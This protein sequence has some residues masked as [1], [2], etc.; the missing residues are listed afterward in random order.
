MSY[1]TFFLQ[2]I[3]ILCP[4]LT[5][6]SN[7]VVERMNNKVNGTVTYA[8]NTNY[9]VTSG[10][11][12]RVCSINGHWSGD[13]PTCSGRCCRTFYSHFICF[14]VIWDISAYSRLWNCHGERNDPAVNVCKT[15]HR[16]TSR[17]DQI[18]KTVLFILSYFYRVLDK[19][20]NSWLLKSMYKVT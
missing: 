10:N 13:P 17:F 7:G 3:E 4:N 8:C 12:R 18:L 5:D 20:R 6:P 15:C 16:K 9:Y 11:L 1:W 19:I 14:G 2:H